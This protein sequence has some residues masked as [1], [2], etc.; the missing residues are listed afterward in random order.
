MIEIILE[1]YLIGHYQIRIEKD[2]TAKIKHKKINSEHHHSNRI[3][4]D[5]EDKE[6][7]KRKEVKISLIIVEWSSY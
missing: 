7:P 1:D 4:V 3:E 5:L 2:L 6:N